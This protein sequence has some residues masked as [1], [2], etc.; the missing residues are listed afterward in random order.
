[1]IIRSYFKE[2]KE[3]YEITIGRLS[4]CHIK[5]NDTLLSKYQCNII[6]NPGDGWILADGYKCKCSTNGTWLYIGESLTITQNMIFK[7]NQ[8]LFQADIESN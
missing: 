1:M 3:L 8:T 4:G 7:A 5:I 6:Y 2:E